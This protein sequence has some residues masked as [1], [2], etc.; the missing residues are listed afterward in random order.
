MIGPNLRRIRSERGWTQPTFATLC[1]LKGWD[2]SRDTLAKI[3]GQSRW[4]ADFELVFL[5]AVL[6]V[7][8]QELLSTRGAKE[9]AKDFIS[10]LE[11]TLE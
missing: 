3:E 11:R 1:Q 10:N 5:A 9:S 2:I 7:P 4:V 6:Q 8:V